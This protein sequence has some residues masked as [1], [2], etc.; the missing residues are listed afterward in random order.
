MLEKN[1]AYCY[2]LQ[3]IGF[4]SLIWTVELS[5]F[6]NALIGVARNWLGMEFTSTVSTFAD[7]FDSGKKINVISRCNGT[8][9]T[10]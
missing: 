7:E 3:L 9:K 10:N 8:R 1:N 2:K 4:F 5:D 6:L